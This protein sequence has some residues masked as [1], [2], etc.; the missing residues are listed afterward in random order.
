MYLQG[1]TA[2]AGWA[3]EGRY[4]KEQRGARGNIEVQSSERYKKVQGGT[5]R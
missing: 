1:E 3:G 2:A 4:R 5:K